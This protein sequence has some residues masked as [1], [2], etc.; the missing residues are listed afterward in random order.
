[1]QPFA[2]LT[3]DDRLAAAEDCLAIRTGQAKARWSA[4]PAWLPLA[5]DDTLVGANLIT[6]PPDDAI[7]Q[8]PACRT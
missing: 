3:D 8:R 2:S 6:L 1:M 7:E 5:A 4:K